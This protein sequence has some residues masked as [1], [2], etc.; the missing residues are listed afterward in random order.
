MATTPEANVLTQIH[1][2]D[3]A[4]ISAQATLAAITLWRE[5]KPYESDAQQA[6]WLEVMVALVRLLNG[7]SAAKARDYLTVFRRLEGIN[8][9]FTIPV[10][11]D[12][13]VERLVASL[14]IVGPHEAKQRVAQAGGAPVPAALDRIATSTAGVAQRHA[15]NG[16]RDT[17]SAAIREDRKVR[18]Y[19]RITDA[20]PC[21]FCAMLASRGPVYDTDS[22]DDS[23]PRFHGPGDYKVH[24]HCNCSLEPIYHVGVNPA[25]RAE[26]F[27]ALWRATGATK[28][29]REAVR[30]F[31]RAY[32]GRAS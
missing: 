32:E 31:R 2:V 24:D 17:I 12:I 25:S 26:E 10:I 23:D 13:D 21:Y 27:E 28:S 1:Q 5:L 19:Q 30:E 9:G 22:F 11:G 4:R 6:R 20:D 16:S 15:V 29:G 3:Q 18:G 7:R 8:D 14:T